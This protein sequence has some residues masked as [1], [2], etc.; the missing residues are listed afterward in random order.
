MRSLSDLQMDA[1][2]S[3]V[4]SGAMQGPLGSSEMIL[5]G[6]FRDLL[7]RAE[8]EQSDDIRFTLTA[9]ATYSG[10]DRLVG[11]EREFLLRGDRLRS[12][13]LEAR[14]LRS[15]R[16]RKRLRHLLRRSAVIDRAS[17]H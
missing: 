4:R 2:R 12:T 17:A 15:W 6:T 9:I 1:T 7:L 3:D 5:L 16:D 10:G 11:A 8:C 14:Q 13:S